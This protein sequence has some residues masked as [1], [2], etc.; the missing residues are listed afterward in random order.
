MKRCALLTI[1]AITLVSCHSVTTDFQ[2]KQFT[3]QQTQS[4]QDEYQEEAYLIGQQEEAYQKN[5]SR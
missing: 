1:T 4:S 2:V 5:T 3:Y